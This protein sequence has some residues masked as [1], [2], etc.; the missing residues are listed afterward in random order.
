MEKAGIFIDGGYLNRVLR[1][2][3][4]TKEINYLE[5][6]EVICKDIGTKRLRTYYYNCMPIKINNR[7]L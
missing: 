7:E 6:S 4:N 1:N 3:Y 2:N 5:L